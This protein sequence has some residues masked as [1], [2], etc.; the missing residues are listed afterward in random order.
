[1][2][3]A[4]KRKVKPAFKKPKTDENGFPVTKAKK[5][6]S[7]APEKLLSRSSIII[8]A[9]ERF[10]LL[11]PHLWNEVVVRMTP[12]DVMLMAMQVEITQNRWSAGAKIAKDILPFMHPKLSHIHATTGES[13]FENYSPE[14]LSFA[15]VAINERLNQTVGAEFIEGRAG[16]S[17]ASDRE[18]AEFETEGDP[19]LP[20]LP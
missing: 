13:P 18:D 20:A 19:P 17:E 14:A 11:F 12:L 6:V 9:A 7:I 5:S 1:M 16:D 2:R 8:D 10:R 15:I 3:K 4:S